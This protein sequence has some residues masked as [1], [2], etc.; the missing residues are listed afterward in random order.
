[1]GD[2]EGGH[3]A[4]SGQRPSLHRE[5]KPTRSNYD[6]GHISFG[7][8]PKYIVTMGEKLAISSSLTLMAFFSW[9]KT[10][11]GQAGSHQLK[12]NRSRFVDLTHPC[13]R[14]GLYQT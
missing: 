1:M 10:E 2:I 5:T 8:P 4:T 14:T 6:I 9:L 13:S 11:V 3:T 12:F 7:H